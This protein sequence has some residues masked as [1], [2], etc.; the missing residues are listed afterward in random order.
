VSE[1]DKAIARRFYDEVMNAHNPGAAGNFCTPEIV[2]HNPYPNQPPGVEGIKSS[3]GQ[4]FTAF[5]DFHFKIES[6]VSE[7]D[8]VVVYGRM[9]GTQTGAFMGFPA[10]GKK[11][12]VA[13]FDM[14]RVANGK[15]KERWGMFE[16]M[17]M[18]MQLGMVPDMP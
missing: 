8:L 15:A 2:D 11:V 17:T 7:G 13:G 14:V 6:M 16:E 12:D 1:Q 5:P 3:L 4:L 18:A 10:S 9:T